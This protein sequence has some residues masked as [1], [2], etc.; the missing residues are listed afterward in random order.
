VGPGPEDDNTLDLL[1]SLWQ[2]ARI[3]K[4]PT[5]RNPNSILCLR[6]SAAWRHSRPPG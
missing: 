6:F 5:V 2:V 3:D 4:V 1:L